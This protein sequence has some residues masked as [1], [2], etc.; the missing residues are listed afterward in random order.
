MG[1]CCPGTTAWHTLQSLVWFWT[2]DGAD[3]LL[4]MMQE[5]SF[6]LRENV[7]NAFYMFW[8][9]KMRVGPSVYQARRWI[10][11]LLALA[12]SSLL[13]NTAGIIQPGNVMSRERGPPTSGYHYMFCFFPLFCVSISV[14]QTVDRF[15]DCSLLYCLMIYRNYNNIRWCFP[16][17]TKLLLGEQ[18]G[19]LSPLFSNPS[20]T[21]LQMSWRRSEC[22]LRG[23]RWRVL[24]GRADT[25]RRSNSK[26]GNTQ[27]GWNVAAENTTENLK[28]INCAFML[29]SVFFPH[30]NKY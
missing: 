22:G 30:L 21:F 11:Q 23:E 2:S 10:L 6:I 28:W 19:M 14:T 16:S 4:Y 5:M 8:I 1:I 18:R 20:R 15:P 13:D 12:S 9:K 3:H 25:V 17:R 27:Q 24:T 29:I 26:L 7:F